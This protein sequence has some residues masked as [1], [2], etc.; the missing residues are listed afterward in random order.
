MQVTLKQPDIEQALKD[1]IANLG[2][3]LVGK[4]VSMTFTAGRKTA[5]ISVELNIDDAAAP[6]LGERPTIVTSIDKAVPQKNEAQAIEEL[7]PAVQAVEEA[8]FETAEE[9]APDVPASTSTEEEPPAQAGGKVS[10]FGN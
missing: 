7:T 2:V 9:V 4:T 10:L 3:N 5:G 8:P 6:S 1:H